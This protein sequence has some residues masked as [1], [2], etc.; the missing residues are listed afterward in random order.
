MLLMAPVIVEVYKVITNIL[1]F[2]QI[3]DDKNKNGSIYRSNNNQVYYMLWNFQLVSFI[4]L[5]LSIRSISIYM[6]SFCQ[7]IFD[8]KKYCYLRYP[9]LAFRSHF[10][11]NHNNQSLY[12]RTCMF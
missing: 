8:D 9:L 10:V 2:I 4:A 11:P 12:G 1:L 3:F 6:V 5:I 7:R